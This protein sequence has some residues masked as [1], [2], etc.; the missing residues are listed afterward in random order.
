M[1]DNTTGVSTVSRNPIKELFERDSIRKRFEEMLGKKAQGFITSVLQ[2][3][4]SNELLAKADP[5]SIYN[6]AATAATMD[7]PINQNLGFAWIVPYYDN[8]KKVYVAQFQMGW[9]GYVQLAQR[10]SQFKTIK[11]AVVYENQI[12]STDHIWNE[13][14][15]KNIKGEGKVAGY[16]AYFALLTGFEKMFFMDKA[17]ADKH[18]K[19]YSQSFRNNKGVWAD[20]EDGFNSMGQKTVLK[21]LLAKFAPLSIEM[22]KAITTDQSVINDE[23]GQDVTYIDN[24]PVDLNKEIEGAE[25]LIEDCKSWED[26]QMLVDSFDADILPA[27]EEKINAKRSI[28]LPE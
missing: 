25:Q 19:K 24:Q 17:T 1:S 16:V 14:Q 13:I 7:L 9:K 23:D 26:L 18:A 4:N 20:G 10:T 22:Q 21:L 27:L 11:V 15:F 2:I 5:M 8:K 28:L 12:D 6:A 3:A